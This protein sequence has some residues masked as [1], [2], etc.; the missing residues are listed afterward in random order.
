MRSRRDQMLGTRDEMVRIEAAPGGLGQLIG[1][2][3]GRCQRLRCSLHPE[4]FGHGNLVSG[5]CLIGL[6]LA[7]LLM[8]FGLRAGELQLLLRG[9]RLL[10]GHSR[11]LLQHVHDLGII[12][13]AG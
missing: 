5:R 12:V 2:L 9:W 1:V 3:V 8:D 6:G 10:G 11:L 13:D 7:F 4:I